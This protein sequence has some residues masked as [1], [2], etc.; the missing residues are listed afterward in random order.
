MVFT[1]TFQATG[2]PTGGLTGEQRDRLFLVLRSRGIALTD[3][4][5]G[6]R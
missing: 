3:P 6:A 4:A 5:L 1:G 2:I